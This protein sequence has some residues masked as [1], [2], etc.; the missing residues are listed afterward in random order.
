MQRRHFVKTSAAA[1]SAVFAAGLGRDRASAASGT[2]ADN[3]TFQLNYAPHPGMFKASAGQD[4]IDQIR[5]S[6]QAGFRAWEFNGLPK[7]TEET[8]QKVGDTLKELGMTMG[9]FVAHANFDRPTFVN[10]SKTDQAEILADIKTSVDVAKRSGAKW[11]TVVP[12]SV[13]QQHA[14]QEKWNKYGGPRLSEG[15]QTANVIEILKRCAEILEPHDLVMVLEPLNWHANH[16]GTF[17]QQSDQA[18]AICKAVDSPSCKILFDIYH[19]QITEG[20]LIPNIDLC[21]DEIAYFQ[22]G[23]NP[24]RKEPG[25]GE[26][27]YRNVFRHIH[28]KGFKGVVGMEHGNSMKGAEGE[29]AVIKAYRDLDAF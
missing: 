6:H 12:G 10:G 15:Y 11:M 14:D 1:A 25:T 18:Y 24:G 7:E 21:W 5:F 8:Q 2:A 22:A 4:V 20:N 29:Q 27:N 16:G 28:S 9:V 19:Q 17:L 3:P 13:D 23:D 26:I